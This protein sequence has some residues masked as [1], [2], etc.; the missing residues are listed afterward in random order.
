MPPDRLTLADGRTVPYAE[1]E[2]L[3]DAERRTAWYVDEDGATRHPFYDDT[4][5]VFFGPGEVL[6]AMPFRRLVAL[7]WTDGELQ[8]AYDAAGGPPGEPVLRDTDEVDSREHMERRHVVFR[9]V[10]HAGMKG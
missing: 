3:P 6:P 4:G 9:F 8:A 10:C 2:A 1:A 5:V 7:G